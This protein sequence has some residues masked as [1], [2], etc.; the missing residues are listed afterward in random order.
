MD[1]KASDM[2]ESGATPTASEPLPS[3]V[4]P[5]NKP[6][7]LF[8][9]SSIL[10]ASNDTPTQGPIGVQVSPSAPLAHDQGSGSSNSS[11]ATEIASNAPWLEGALKVILSYVSDGSNNTS[12]VNVLYH[13]QPCPLSRAV[14]G[15]P[16]AL[17]GIVSALQTRFEQVS[18]D[19]YIEVTHAV[20]SRSSFS[21]LPNS[22]VTTPNRPAA[23]ASMG[24]YFSMPRTVVFAKG[25]I[26]AS[27]AESRKIL[28]ENPI[29]RAIPQT[30]VVPSSIA[31]SVLERFIPPATKAEYLDLFKWDQPSALVDRMA[32]LKPDNGNLVFVYP[33]RK[34]ALTFRNDYLGPILDPLLRTMMGVHGISPTLVYEIAKLEAIDSMRDFEQLKAKV[35]QLIA[36]MNGK[37][38]GK[39]HRFTIA[40]ASKQSVH[41]GRDAWAEWLTE[42]ELPRLRDIM[43]QYYGRAMHLP[44][45]GDFTAAGLVREVVDGIKTRAYEVGE[46]PREGI[47]IG[48]F[49][50]KRLQ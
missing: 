7:S 27:H 24:D 11:A 34:G 13:L 5:S 33:T 50:I 14:L 38:G 12:V 30:V 39:L 48:V 26:A 23:E 15:A 46:A 4:H 18:A 20:S 17:D 21:Q 49:V 40:E 6:Q 47:E 37:V 19:R 10:G 16:S 28:A 22:P 9:G 3:N 1:W 32:E 29:N 8:S 35:A 25:T 36:K 42:Q 2:D 31:I 45:S 41:I 43:N 44:Q